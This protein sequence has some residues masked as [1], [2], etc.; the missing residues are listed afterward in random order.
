ME[1]I[2]E[3]ILHVNLQ[4]QSVSACPQQLHGIPN[5]QMCARKLVL[6]HSVKKKRDVSDFSP[7]AEKH[8]QRRHCC[9][10]AI[11]FD[12]DALCSAS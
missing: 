8:W 12:N 3:M 10:R 5:N 4:G 1:P 7:L 11:V 2:C 9:E 6:Q